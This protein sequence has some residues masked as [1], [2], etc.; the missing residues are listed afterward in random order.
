MNK[1]FREYMLMLSAVLFVVGII[2]M[3]IG[4]LWYFTFIQSGTVNT[5][6]EG[7][8]EKLGEWGW[9]VLIP[10]PFILISGT[11][12]FFDQILARKI[13]NELI[14][15]NSKAKLVKNDGE[16]EEVIWKLPMKYKVRFEEK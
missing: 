1:I 6:V 3:T 11:W 12:Y 16:I 5:L 9:W 7:F 10:A 4:V 13:F 14:S 15:P 8:S 2:M